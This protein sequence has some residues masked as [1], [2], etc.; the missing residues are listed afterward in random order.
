[1][2]LLILLILVLLILLILVL[3]I[4]PVFQHLLRIGIVLLR[5]EVGRVQQQRLPE[6]FHGGLI[7]LPGKG[8]VSG[9][10]MIVGATFSCLSYGLESLGGGI[11]VLLAVQRRRQ[12]ILGLERGGILE[13]RLAVVDFRGTVVLLAE[14][15]VAPAHVAPVILCGRGQQ[16]KQQ[17]Y[18]GQQAFHI[19]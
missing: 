11:I 5:L 19:S 12:V 18:Y 16:R 1:M 14:L 7:V 6:I 10:E 15:S 4:L 2:I 17:Q 8:Y 3:L 13:N 9:V